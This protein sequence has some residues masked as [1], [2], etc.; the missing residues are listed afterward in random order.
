MQQVGKT[1]DS[2]NIIT[3]LSSVHAC[4]LDDYADSHK[5]IHELPINHCAPR[6]QDLANYFDMLYMVVVHPDFNVHQD[7]ENNY[8]F[9]LIFRNMPE[10]RSNLENPVRRITDGVP[11][12]S[13]DASS[14]PPPCPL[15]RTRS[16]GAK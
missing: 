13:V 4:Y 3:P 16:R 2:S 1:N 7:Q 14:L 9:D 15:L 12:K 5:P 10:P 8:D 11:T 6:N